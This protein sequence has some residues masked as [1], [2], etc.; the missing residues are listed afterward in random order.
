MLPYV[1]MSPVCLDA[2]TCLDAPPVCLNVP[3][4]LDG[5]LYVLMPHIF[6]HPPYVWMH[7]MFGYPLFGYPSEW[8]DAPHLFGHSPV[9]LDVLHMFGCP[10]YVWMPPKCMGHPKV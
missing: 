1:W 6:G 2:A 5:P 4:C 8:S 7:C 9:Y 10:Q 3:I